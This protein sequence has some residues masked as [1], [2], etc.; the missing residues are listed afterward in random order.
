MEIPLV[1]GVER[2]L[3]EWMGVSLEC[4]L[5]GLTLTAP[6]HERC[7]IRSSVENFP[8][9]LPKCQDSR[10]TLMEDQMLLDNLLHGG[11]AVRVRKQKKMQ[12]EILRE[13]GSL[14]WTTEKQPGAGMKNN[15]VWRKTVSRDGWTSSSC[16]SE[17]P[18]RHASKAVWE[19]FPV[20]A[21]H[22]SG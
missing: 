22:A 11:T 21:L 19:I 5:Q 9:F 8:S 10:L 13:N 16:H 4:G 12:P 1:L 3:S 2:E 17:K 20:S 7:W 6:N 18:L 15:T 14:S